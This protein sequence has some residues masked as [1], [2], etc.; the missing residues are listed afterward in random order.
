MAR[1]LCIALWVLFGVAGCSPPANRAQLTKEVL[2]ADP[3]FGAVLDKHREL[4]SRIETYRRELELKRTTIQREIDQRQKEL[5]SA[6]ASVRE[7]TEKT[8]GQMEP[9]RQRLGLA[10]S[11]AGEELRKKRDQR[12]SLGRQIAQ[13]RK[14]AK[15]PNATWT[16]EERAKQQAGID[17]LLQQAA[18][19][20]QEMVALKSTIRLLKVKLLL[21]KL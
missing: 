14:A 8:K 9:E 1:F 6:A 16:P 19:L 21:I 12:T 3:D 5:A 11:M 18:K 2:A 10:L 7:K 4:M 13:L 17:G 15:S 20:D